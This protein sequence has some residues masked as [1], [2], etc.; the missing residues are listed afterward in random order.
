MLN[1]EWLLSECE[2]LERLDS[3]DQ[4]FAHLT[5]FVDKIEFSRTLYTVLPTFSSFDPNTPPYA[6]LT[7]Y[8][9]EWMT[10]YQEKGY[11]LNDSALNHC[12]SGTDAPYLHDERQSLNSLCQPEQR[13]IKDA[14]QAGIKNLLSIPMNNN[15]G[16]VGVLS[17]SHHGKGSDFSR[18]YQEQYELI[19]LYALTLNEHINK[20][21]ANKI[22][23]RFGRVYTP[24]ITAKERE[25]LLLL[26]EG[27]TYDQIAHKLTVGV[28]TIRKHTQSLLIKLK[29]R[30]TTHACALALRWGLVW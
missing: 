18:L 17:L 6:F 28:S 7:N 22:N 30:N 15:F 23:E 21:V 19:Q 5:R 14:H 24:N 16:A 25:V 13:V 26:V 3:L 27:C 29:A 8:D 10:Y 2:K 12:L 9:D 1:R 20:N 11:H 4:Y